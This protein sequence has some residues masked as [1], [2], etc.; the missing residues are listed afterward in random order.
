MNATVATLE[1]QGAT[2]V[3]PARIPI[4]PAY[5][6]E[7][8]A[9]LCEFKDD[10]AT[11]LHAY[12]R[13]GYPKTLQDLIDFNDA[14]PALEGPWNSEI[15]VEA[16]ATGGRAD[17]ACTAARQAATSTAQ[18]AIDDLLAANHLDAIIAPTNGPAWVTDPVNGD[19]GGDF[20]TFV[21]S[22]SPSAIAGYPSITVPAGFDGPLPLG[23]SFI[24]GR[25]DEP[26]LI[27]LAYAFE[28]A[29][30]VRVPPRFLAT[31]PV[32]P[33]H[34]GPRRCAAPA[35]PFRRPRRAAGVGRPCG[36]RADRPTPGPGPARRR[37]HVSVDN[38][39]EST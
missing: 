27:G 26:T 37:G 17:P 16:Q 9:L 29:T 13:R 20:S 10:I 6:P 21:G 34:V 33:A 4:E 12:T 7:F 22:S 24:G 28:Q 25:W 31:L 19:L 14:H 32:A 8:T 11:Y 35:V 18:A 15:F 1:A 2:I 36:S 3:D 38:A 39:S 30:H 5:G 23:V